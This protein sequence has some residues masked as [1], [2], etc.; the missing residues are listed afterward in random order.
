MGLKKKLKGVNYI[1]VKFNV[2]L[3]MLKKNKKNSIFSYKN[4]LI[5]F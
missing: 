5:I 1:H 3:K 2:S 4:M